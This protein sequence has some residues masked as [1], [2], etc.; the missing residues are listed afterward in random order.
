MKTTSNKIRKTVLTV[1]FGLMMGLSASAQVF[2]LGEGNKRQNTDINGEYSNVIT[3]GLTEDQTN[4]VPVGSGSL[5]L[6]AM[7]GAYLIGKKVSR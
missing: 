7:G 6:A 3:H 5:L 1:A 2:V 4:Y